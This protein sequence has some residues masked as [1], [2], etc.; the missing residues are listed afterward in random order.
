VL[1]ALN[2]MTVKIHCLKTLNYS[3][4]KLYKDKFWRAGTFKMVNHQSNKET[5]LNFSD[6][7]FNANLTDDDFSQAALQRAGN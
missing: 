7:N 5:I 6:Y 3:D 4:Y 1:K 2:F